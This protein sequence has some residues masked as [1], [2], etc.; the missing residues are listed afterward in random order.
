MDYA[1]QNEASR[2]I[3]KSLEHAEP[4][5]A[6]VEDVLLDRIRS[7]GSAD[8]LRSLELEVPEMRTALAIAIFS[9]HLL[10]RA[11]IWTDVQRSD[12]RTVGQSDGQT[13]GALVL[14]EEFEP[15]PFEEA[16]DF[17][18]AKTNVPPA[19]FR[20]LEAAA[21]KKAFAIAAGATE[22]ITASVREL[23]DTAL[24]DG[25][26]LKEFQSQ[27]ADVLARAGVT[28]KSSWYWETVY[29]TNLQTSYQAGRWKQ[30]TDDYVK[31]RRPYLRY[32]SART[33][34]SRPSHIEKHGLV[35]PV[36]H[37]FWD[38]WMP[39]NG[40]NCL[41]SVSS[42]SEDLLERRGWNV[43][44]AADYDPPDEGFATNPGKEEI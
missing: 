26:S 32:V 24:S 27:A 16:I 9:L 1:E 28:A 39:P 44:R 12:S 33:P 8:A 17:F 36:E 30:M 29:R 20:T 23:L 40:F 13:F 18:A 6:R 10:G 5:I 2:V 3:E 19:V 31:E 43:S 38:E 34:T 15:L 41:C 25:M 21:K 4:L 37:P 11:Q 35:F 42:V 14:E 22:Q 7:A